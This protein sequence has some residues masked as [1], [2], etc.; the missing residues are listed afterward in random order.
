MAIVCWLR[1]N[2]TWYFIESEVRSIQ[3]IQE[4]TFVHVIVVQEKR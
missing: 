2:L 1:A 3:P 4:S